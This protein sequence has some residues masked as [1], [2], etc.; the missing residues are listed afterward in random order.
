MKQNEDCTVTASTDAYP[1]LRR[2][3]RT[4]RAEKIYVYLN[5]YT[6]INKARIVAVK[7]QKHQ[8]CIN[9]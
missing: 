2:Q 7:L 9:D 8:P 4:Y 5:C 6:N 3:L 1:Q